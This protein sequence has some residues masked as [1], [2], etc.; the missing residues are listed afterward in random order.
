MKLNGS[1]V[2]LGKAEWNAEQVFA[3]ERLYCA[4]TVEAA[5]AIGRAMAEISSEDIRRLPLHEITGIIAHGLIEVAMRQIMAA[6]MPVTI[7]EFGM[8]ARLVYASCH[9]HQGDEGQMQ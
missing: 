5:K 6:Q 2:E 4:V 8:A 1:A 7:D 3:G 9:Q